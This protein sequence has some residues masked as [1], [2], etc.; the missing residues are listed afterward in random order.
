MKKAGHTHGDIAEHLGVSKRSVDR[1]VQEPPVDNIDCPAARTRR[2]IGRPSKVAAFQEQ[3]RKTL[4]GEPGLPSLELLRRARMWGYDGG[5]SA[6]YTMVRELRPPK[7]HVVMRFEAVPG[8]F[9]QHD[10]GEVRVRYLD[11]S[12]ER[13]VFFATRMKFSRWVVVSLVPNQTAETLVRTTCEHFEAIGGVPL[14]AVFDRPKTVALEWRK[15]GTVTRFN[16][17]F[18]GAMFEMGVGVEVCWPYAPQQKGAVEKLVGWVK[19]SFFKVRRFQ[20]RDDLEAQ[21]QAWLREMN[22]E[23]P[24]RAT[25]VAPATRMLTE[26]A[27]LRPL[28]VRPDQLAVRRPVHVGPTAMVSLEGAQY[29]MPPDAAGW[30]GTA[31]LYPDRVEVVAG[32]HRAVHPRLPSGGKSTLPEH[33]AARLAHVS[34]RRGKSYLMR[35]DIMELGDIALT[36]LDELVHRRP[37]AWHADVVVLHGLLQLHGE[38][39]LRLAMHMAVA[40]RRFSGE[41]VASHLVHVAVGGV[42]QE[43]LPC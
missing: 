8:E 1:V 13:V 9:S 20:D 2:R 3:V 39:P 12:T 23:R 6:F 43:A 30:S 38:G 7:A 36:L 32:Q 34:G 31:W 33:R 40:E 24:S 16:P 35:Q 14:L 10:F 29:S 25:G 17:I 41:A 5:K 28:K 11:G 19:G 18:A 22:E 37:T 42:P 15:D 26:R 21:L 4:E 27:R